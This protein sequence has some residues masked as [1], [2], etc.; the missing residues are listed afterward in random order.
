MSTKKGAALDPNLPPEERKNVT[1][2]EYISICL[3]RI[4]GVFGTTLTGTLAAAFLYELYFG[5]VGVDS[6][7]I[8][9][10]SAVQTIRFLY[11][12]NP[13]A[14]FGALPLLPEAFV[15]LHKI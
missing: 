15:F 2:L 1:R 5:P 7:G 10:I 14:L 9:K 11:F 4:G 13:Q 12:H 6:N 3:A 8:A